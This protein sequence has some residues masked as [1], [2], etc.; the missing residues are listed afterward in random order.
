MALVKAGQ[1]MELAMMAANRT[2]GVG[3]ADIAERFE[4]SQRT[5]QRMLV[6]LQEVFSGVVEETGDDQRKRWRLPRSGLREL[7]SLTPDEAAALDHA[8]KELVTVGHAAEAR[9]L[10]TL[11]EKILTLVP[12]R[13]AA[14]F[15]TDY[16]ALLEAQGFVARP[17]P[18]PIADPSVLTPVIEAI[19]GFRALDISYRSRKDARPRRRR[20]APYGILTGLRR[21]LVAQA[22]E[23]RPTGPI[24]LFRFDAISG[25]ALS[26]KSFERPPGFSLSAF[27]KR[28]FGAY[29]TDAEYGE[30]V[31]RFAPEAA[32][33]A[34]EFEFHPDQVLEARPDGSLIV[35]FAAA[36]HLEMCWH[37]YAWGDKVE[38]LAPDSLRAMCH[39]YR[40]GDFPALP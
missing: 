36:G 37:L 12:A 14:R 4:C 8:I 3:L 28:A 33:Q 29:Q 2:Q 26:E 1:L 40:R 24:R 18:K 39:A 20:I 30:V 38:V 34:R 13:S 5:A 17:G 9:H 21:Y 7:L 11:R 16:E 32:A 22:I 10:A 15:E 23:D 6:R 31:W 19:K 25:A 35:R 27:A